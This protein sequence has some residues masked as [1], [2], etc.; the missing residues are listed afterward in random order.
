M[1]GIAFGRFKP[2]FFFVVSGE[3]SPDEA[4]VALV[5]DKVE[6]LVVVA[7]SADAELTCDTL[8]VDKVL[9]IVELVIVEFSTLKLSN[10][11]LFIAVDFVTFKDRKF[12]DVIGL[13]VLR[14]EASLV[15]SVKLA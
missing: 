7:V 6:K 15:V 13:F 1:V 11:E 5:D 12:S 10:A 14:E 4:V 9:K 8:S 3:I 2:F